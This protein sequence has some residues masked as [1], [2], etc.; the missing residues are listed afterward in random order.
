VVRRTQCIGVGHAMVQVSQCSIGSW[1]LA[2][3]NRCRA[4]VAAAMVR[5]KHVGKKIVAKHARDRN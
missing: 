1:A 3:S 5:V 2:W 4:N